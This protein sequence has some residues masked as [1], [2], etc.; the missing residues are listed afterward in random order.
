M[1][2]APVYESKVS[3]SAAS[4][5]Y[6]DKLNVAEI[7]KMRGNFWKTHGYFHD[8]LNLLYPEEALYL[9][10]KGNITFEATVPVESEKTAGV[11]SDT[12]PVIVEVEANDIIEGAGDG[13][14]LHKPEFE[15]SIEKATTLLS[16]DKRFD[17]PSFYEKIVNFV[18]LPY[19][20]VYS[21]LKV[22]LFSFINHI[23][24]KST[25]LIYI[26]FSS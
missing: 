12:D 26:L 16:I 11:S 4:C 25:K 7:V 17:F 23:Y 15:D 13:A 5:V 24:T 22:H 19:Y 9:L 14:E 3:N 20:L 6:H 1:L 2:G 21:K 8:G 18:S 10:E